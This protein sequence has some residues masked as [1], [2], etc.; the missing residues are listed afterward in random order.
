MKHLGF[1]QQDICGLDLSTSLL[2]SW[3]VV[4]MIVAELSHLERLSLKS[5]VPVSLQVHVLSFP[6][7]RN[8]FSAMKDVELMSSAFPKLKELQLNGTLM[9][10]GEIQEVISYMPNLQAIEIGYNHLVVLSTLEASVPIQSS[11]YSMN[12]DGNECKDWPHVCLS[13]K[14]YPL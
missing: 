11:L 4:A 1:P 9:T 7:S 14:P 13:L 12:L 5:V 3:D 8:R 2:P 6:N 10:F